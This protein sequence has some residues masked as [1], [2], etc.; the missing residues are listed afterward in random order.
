ML[1]GF[2]MSRKQV[3]ELTARLGD[4][5]MIH[6]VSLLFGEGPVSYAPDAEAKQE[7]Y[8]I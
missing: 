5:G 4:C 8:R 3:Q 6:P 7:D 2:S 1:G